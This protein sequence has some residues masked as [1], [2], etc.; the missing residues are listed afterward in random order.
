[1][2]GS[3]PG[4][5]SADVLFSLVLTKVLKLIKDRA[6][7]QG[8]QLH[9]K[10]TAGD[11]SDVVTW[12]DDIA[13][14]LTG[15]AQ[16]LVSKTMKLLAIVQDTMLEHGL[17]LSYG[18]GKTAVMFS[19]HGPG[20][21]AARQETEQKYRDGLPLLSEHKGKSTFQLLATIVILGALWSVLD[22]VCRS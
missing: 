20:A 21:T 7:E 10:A 17:A 4:D 2:T 9:H 13:F 14:S 18:V 6:G 16:Q 5:P 3:R 22:H 15:E 1:M 12:V 11:V 8:I 19:F